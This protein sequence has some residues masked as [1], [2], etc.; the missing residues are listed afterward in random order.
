MIGHRYSGRRARTR[1]TSARFPLQELYSMTD[2]RPG[3]ESRRDQP[4][5]LGGETAPEDAEAAAGPAVPEDADVPPPV[6]G[7]APSDGQAPP[8]AATTPD[9]QPPTPIADTPGPDDVVFARGV[10][11]AFDDRTVVHD[12]DLVVKRGTILGVIGPSGSGKTTTIRMI[13]GA[14]QPT[15]GEITV[16]GERPTR[17]RRSTRERI[18]YMP[19]LFTLYPDLTGRENVDFVA[20]LFGLLWPRRRRRIKQVLK[21]LNLWDARNRRASKLSGGMQRRLE[22]ACALVHDPALLILDE[23]TAGIDPLLR[24]TVWEEL[25]RLRDEGRTLLVTTQYV[26][27][28]EE[29]DQ[30]ALIVNGRLIAVAPPE[31]LRRTALGGDA[32]EVETAG[33]FD[34][35]VLDTV[36][37]VHHVQQIGPRELRIRVADAATGLPTVVDA[38]GEAGGEVVSA[39]ELRLSFDEIFAELVTRANENDDQ[40]DAA[41]ARESVA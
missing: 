9:D 21:L 36:P 38:V 32:I 17:F 3:E 41:G 8:E 6:D 11:R 18:G 26:N 22:L 29:C 5:E 25:H 12:I 16:L 13:T 39:R 33:L 27:E 19:Q 1:P 15:S 40:S 34:G 7:A 35:T 31:E 20:S 37:G 2:E 30:V 23:P 4:S 24:V 14:L 28:A 10:S